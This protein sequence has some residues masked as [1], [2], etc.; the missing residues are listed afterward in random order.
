MSPGDDPLLDP[1]ANALHR[2]TPEQVEAAVEACVR[3]GESELEALAR[4][5][6]A[7]SQ[8]VPAIEAL[9][10]PVDTLASALDWLSSGCASPERQT[11]LE[12]HRPR[13]DA[14]LRRIHAHDGL[15]RHVSRAL[16]RSELPA[17][18]RR[19]LEVF[20][21]KQWRAGADL[22]PAGRRDLEHLDAELSAATRAFADHV[23]REPPPP[24]WR[25][26]LTQSDDRARR[27]EVYRARTQRC[28]GGRHDNES[29][30]GRILDLRNRRAGL[31]RVESFAELVLPGRMLDSPRAVAA[32]LDELADRLGPL[33]HTE[34][35]H[36]VR[37]ARR[38]RPDLCGLQAWD[39]AYADHC[40]RGQRAKLEH[41]LSSVD[42]LVDR[43]IELLRVV[44]GFD[45]RE[46]SAVWHPAVR[47]I[48]LH[49]D[50]GLLARVWLDL[51]RRPSKRPGCWMHPLRVGG[52]RPDLTGPDRFE[53]HHAIVVADLDP[54]APVAAA[55]V[56]RVLHEFGHLVHHVASRVELPSL[57]ATRTPLDV[58]ELPAVAMERWVE[59]SVLASSFGL[60]TGDDSDH[61]RATALMRQIGWARVDL[62]LHTQHV[63]DPFDLARRI[64]AAHVPTALPDD[65]GSLANVEHLFVH[66]NGYAAG[67]YAYAWA[68]VLAA[69]LETVG[70]HDLT[71]RAAR[72]RSDFLAR[73]NSR[74]PEAL[75]HPMHGRPPCVAPLLRRLEEAVR[76]GDDG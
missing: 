36:L 2:A 56:R 71:S 27:R 42:D 6:E 75:I 53:P 30:V 33:M 14:L 13:L 35:G 65:D 39:L 49:G 43:L 20:A 50:P 28:L 47:S 45:V 48:E 67:Y 32:M 11:A 26:V 72:L 37:W 54:H 74:A 12:Q 55:D 8:L 22:D 15:R 17:L 9:L 21:L 5:P 41:R 25:A 24:D 76:S 40:R 4:A 61:R 57:A 38:H 1:G 66:P 58:V 70:P 52:P 23:Q 19:A 3:A 31:L 46:A 73:G 51:V 16:T 29:L 69:D 59:H 34:H 62:A 60:P 10:E 18:Q 44:F 7:S 63:Q 64:L 68:E